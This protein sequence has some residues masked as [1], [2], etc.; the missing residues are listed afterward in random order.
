MCIKIQQGDD[1]IDNLEYRFVLSGITT[2]QVEAALPEST[3]LEAN[4]WSI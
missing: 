3:W 2:T 1:L 4:I